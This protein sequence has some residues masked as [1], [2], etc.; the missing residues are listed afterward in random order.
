MGLASTT[1]TLSH[2]DI[3]RIEAA[4]D[5]VNRREVLD[6][7]H[8]HSFLVPI[9]IEA[10]EVIPRYFPPGSSLALEVFTEP[11]FGEE[12]IL[13]ALIRSRLDT[14]EAHAHLD[15]LDEEWWLDASVGAR[16]ELV[17]DVQSL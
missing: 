11:D 8:Q 12:R 10:S 16:G 13:F 2:A 6:L 15:R 9:L 5:L 7:L 17:V 3:A 4:Y 14:F 1:T